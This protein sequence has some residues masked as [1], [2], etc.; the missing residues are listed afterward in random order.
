MGIC[1]AD[2]VPLVVDSWGQFM[3]L[4][5][6]MGCSEEMNVSLGGGAGFLR[7]NSTLV[8]LAL[9]FQHLLCHRRS[10]SWW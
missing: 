1:L 9:L 3:M 7:S 4:F 5:E 8:S 6:D 10:M 2:D